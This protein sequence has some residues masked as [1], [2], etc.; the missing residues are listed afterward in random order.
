MGFFQKSEIEYITLNRSFLIIY[1][2]TQNLKFLYYLIFIDIKADLKLY[3][4][5]LGF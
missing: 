4:L 5:Y 3:K 1:D 2:K